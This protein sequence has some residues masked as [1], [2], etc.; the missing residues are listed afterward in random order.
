MDELNFLS[1]LAT[2]LDDAGTHDLPPGVATII[3]DSVVAALASG[4]RAAIERVQEELETF[5]LHRLARSPSDAGKAARGECDPA[6]P[7]SAAFALGQIGL[8][9]AVVAR[10]ASRRADD[11]FERLIL[12][13]PLER[14]IR[15]LL[16]AELNGRELAEALDKDEAEVS[17]RL[18]VL[19]NIGAVE[20]RRE[21][22]RLLNFLTPAARTVARARNMG[23]IG[24]PMV[25]GD[26]R[27]EVI[28]ALD[29]HRL[30]LDS[31]LRSTLLFVSPGARRFRR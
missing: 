1:D 19:R 12:S 23:A 6:S 10:E 9:H 14:Y 29:N 20:C 28:I 16:D 31:Q 27:P 8:A 25:H 4:E 30:E 15:L 11:R 18:K 13:R 5:Y 26:L 7:S 24:A 22:T 2:E 3:V 17:R 21:G